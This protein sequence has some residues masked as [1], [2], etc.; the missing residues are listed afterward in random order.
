MVDFGL[1]KRWE[2]NE[3]TAYVATRWYRAPEVILGLHY[4]C[5]IDIFAFGS[6]MLEMFLGYEA[7]PGND[8]IDQLNRIFS[9]SGTPTK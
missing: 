6:V 9:V 5:E 1:T 4:D 7:F 2:N 8:A 3:N